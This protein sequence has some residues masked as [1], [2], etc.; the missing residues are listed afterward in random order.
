VSEAVA[1]WSDRKSLLAQLEK[2]WEKGFLLRDY[3]EP[4]DLFPRRLSFKR[5][6]SKALSNEFEAVRQWIADIEKLSG[7]RIVHKIVR[8]RVI[9]EN[10]IPSEAWVDTLET[11]VSLLHKQPQLASFVELLDTTRVRAPELVDWVRQYPLKALSL[12]GIW[13]QLLDFVLWRKQHATPDIYLRQVSL[14]G[15]DS[16]FVEQHRTVLAALLDRVLTPGQID[17]TVT[18]AR[19][20]EQRYGFR[21]KPATVRFRLLDVELAVLPGADQDIA[22]TSRDFALLGQVPALASHLKTVFITENEI[23]FLAFPLQ[24]NSLVIFGAGYGFEAL[25]AADW[26]AQVKLVY[27]GDI[28]THGFAILD[29]LRGRFP[30]VRSLLMDESTL[31]AHRE[32]WGQEATAEGRELHRLTAEEQALYRALVTNTLGDHL[33]LE[34]ERVRYD[35]LMATL[36]QLELSAPQADAT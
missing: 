24:Q 7:F 36:A 11:V 3:L 31:M 14:P 32:F 22:L 20:F 21:G 13:P 17:S 34:Q 2:L 16:K 9:G 26:L 8:H 4:G 23:N 33:R 30:H 12:A 10:R 6:D 19:L 28:D 1:T 29:Q 18:G 35:H 27:W 15:I 5:P 25:T